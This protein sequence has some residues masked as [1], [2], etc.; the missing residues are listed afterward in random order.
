MSLHELYDELEQLYRDFALFS[1]K[2]IQEDATGVQIYRGK[3]D[4]KIALMHAH[5]DWRD[6]ETDLKEALGDQII[7]DD[8]FANDVY[9]ALCNVDWIHKDGT[10]YGCTFREAG[11]LIGKIRKRGESYLD[12]HD[13]GNK[14]FVAPPIAQV[15]AKYGW[16]P[17][18]YHFE[19]LLANF[20]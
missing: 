3:I 6:F 18:P 5:P 14:G 10:V 16:E 4:A 19:L 12:F 9:A 2:E 1:V 11:R 15:L 7:H 8:E 20:T 13:A 17:Q